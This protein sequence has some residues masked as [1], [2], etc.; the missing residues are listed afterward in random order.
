MNGLSLLSVSYKQGVGQEGKDSGGE[1]QVI[2]LSVRLTEVVD[3]RSHA[4]GGAKAAIEGNEQ[5]RG[6][7]A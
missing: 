3:G 7:M 2:S 1:L 5:Q 4:R 6:R